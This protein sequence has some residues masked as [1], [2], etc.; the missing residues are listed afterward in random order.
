M[1]TNTFLREAPLAESVKQQHEEIGEE[2]APKEGEQKK[3]SSKK[4]RERRR[5]KKAEAVAASTGTTTLSPQLPNVAPTATHLLAT[6]PPIAPIVPNTNVGLPAP[7]GDNQPNL[8]PAPVPSPSFIFGPI[9]TAFGQSPPASLTL[10]PVTQPMPFAFGPVSTTFTQTPPPP[11]PPPPH[12]TF[13]EAE[14]NLRLTAAKAVARA[15]A[16]DEI[17][18][19]TKNLEE[20]KKELAT[21]KE[22]S[23]TMKEELAKARAER[24]MA[25]ETLDGAERRLGAIKARLAWKT[26][27]LEEAKAELDSEQTARRGFAANVIVTHQALVASNKKLSKGLLL[28]RLLILVLLLVLAFFF[29]SAW[30]SVVLPLAV[31][32]RIESAHMYP[33]A[34]SMAWMAM[35]EFG[36]F[37]E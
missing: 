34:M 7:R 23:V 9:T 28:A 27:E 6:I 12:K 29:C 24:E 22:E 2:V 37:G 30:T 35:D 1:S 11:P 10:P 3:G 14:V 18:T 31:V 4:R 17:I 33:E 8:A 16:D 25:L 20:S 21:S 36:W 15:E 19:L 32:S 26:T 13:T 5:N